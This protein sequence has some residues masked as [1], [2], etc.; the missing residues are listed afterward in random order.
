MWVSGRFA[1]SPT[2]DLHLGNLRTAAIAWLLARSRGAGFIV[3]MEDLDRQQASVDIEADQLRD[4]AR[5]GLDWDGEV[6]RQS[7]RFDRYDAVIAELASRGLVYECF[8]SRREIREE[9]ESA[10]HAPHGPPGSYPGTCRRLT[11][12][13]RAQRRDTGRRPALRLR[14]DGQEI[15][16]D[17]LVHGTVTGLVDD[18]V[19]R[20]NDGVPAYN[21][22][23]VVDDAAQ[24]VTEVVR[25]D[26]LLASTARQIHLQELIGVP[27][28][29]YAHVPLVVD[30]AGERLAKRQGLPLTLTELAEAGRRR[31]ATSCAGSLSRSATTTCARSPRSAISSTSSIRRRSRPNRVSC[32]LS[33]G[34]R[35]AAGTFALVT[36]PPRVVPV[37]SPVVV[38]QERTRARIGTVVVFGL[39]ALVGCS[40]AVSSGMGGEGAAEA[41]V[42]ENADAPAPTTLAPRHHAQPD[43]HACAADR[44]ASSPT[45]RRRR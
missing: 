38:E 16:F 28:P 7:D 22:A 5:L 43:H 1:P 20:R 45:P 35:D 25:G 33:L 24:G 37:G 11:S 27:R 13:Q 32:P 23:V 21:L 39:V 6:I 2:G 31:R 44:P 29:R 8:C 17:D 34:R 18:V 15:T 40:T 14:T 26:D 10:A 42:V 3:R 9:I 12:H 4:L 19:L 30:A 36:T 41:P